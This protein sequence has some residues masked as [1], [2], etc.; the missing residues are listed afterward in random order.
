MDLAV[1]N[2]LTALVEHHCGEHGQV[3]ADEFDRMLISLNIIEHI[4]S[5]GRP[6]RREHTG[7]RDRC[8]QRVMKRLKLKNLMLV[9]IG[10]TRSGIYRIV[11]L[12]VGMAK[13][14][15]RLPSDQERIGL[16]RVKSFVGSVLENM[17]GVRRTGKRKP[18]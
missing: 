3:D 13:R 4:P 17:A 5:V 8:R 15:E 16:G 2:T 18:R 6:G 7:L 9:T 12:R 10:N 14:L 11:P 1:L